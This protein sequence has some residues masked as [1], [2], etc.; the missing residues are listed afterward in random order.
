MHQND[1]VYWFLFGL[2]PALRIICAV[3]PLTN[4]DWVDLSALML[5]A[6]GEA[7]HMEAKSTTVHVA[8]VTTDNVNCVY[9][10]S[11]LKPLKSPFTG[12]PLA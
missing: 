2:S 7:I 6:K 10:R 3:Q 9:Q 11:V 8:A 4:I 12:H 5:Y 1:L